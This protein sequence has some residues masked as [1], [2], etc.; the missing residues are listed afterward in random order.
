MKKL[1]DTAKTPESSLQCPHCARTFARER[2]VYNH[3]CEQ[4]RR[5]D[6]RDRPSNRIGYNSWLQF[7]SKN[8][9]P[10]VP[11]KYEDFIKSSYYLA[12]VRYGN[13]CVDAGVIN[14]GRYLDWLLKNK[15]KIDDW[16]SDSV[17]TKYLCEYL[18]DED[19]YDALSRSVQTTDDLCKADELQC[20]DMLRWGNTNRV[21]HAITTGKI[22]PWMLYHSESG[23]Q[24]LN[25]LD[26]TQVKMIFDY[27]NPELWAL[28]FKRR[29]EQV[30]EIKQLL[31][32]AG[33]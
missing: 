1:K 24:F 22:S 27:I 26:E 6:D 25:K 4:K 8:V 10:K 2:T 16:S 14:P 15:I 9:M 32:Q 28:T 7:Y 17:Y 11:R 21:C 30:H 23:V 19:P 13:Y 3:V 5:W 20:R 29:A 18:R 12:F 31:K 33:Y